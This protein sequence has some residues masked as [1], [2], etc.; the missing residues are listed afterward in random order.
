MNRFGWCFKTTAGNNAVAT[1]HTVVKSFVT[2]RDECYVAIRIYHFGCFREHFKPGVFYLLKMPR[3]QI[4][5]ILRKINCYMSMVQWFCRKYIILYY[6][7]KNKLIIRLEVKPHISFS[8][9]IIL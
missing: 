5:R 3:Q 8:C 2:Y 7:I 6:G 9:R 4:I 1:D